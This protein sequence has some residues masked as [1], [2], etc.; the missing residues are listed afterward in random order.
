[1]KHSNKNHLRLVSP[2]SLAF[3]SIGEALSQAA[4]WIIDNNHIQDE[5]IDIWL[6]PSVGYEEI[7]IKRY[8]LQLNKRNNLDGTMTL[9]I[10]SGEESFSVL[11][12]D[13]ELKPNTLAPLIEALETIQH[14]RKGTFL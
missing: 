5:K 10:D 13:G 7:R 3:F 2:L 11:F 8:D 6:G 4:P 12:E 1:M 14:R 9:A